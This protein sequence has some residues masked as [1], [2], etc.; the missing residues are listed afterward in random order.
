[1][2]VSYVLV[3]SVAIALYCTRRM[4]V[5]WLALE[6]EKNALRSSL[7]E[8][9]RQLASSQ[10]G[11]SFEAEA[12]VAR[13][14]VA[15]RSAADA[16]RFSAESSVEEAR[17]RSK[18]IVDAAEQQAHTI[19]RRAHST[20]G[21][22]RRFAEPAPTD[23]EAADEAAEGDKALWN[24]GMDATGVRSLPAVNENPNISRLAAPT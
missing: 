4:T 2:F 22:V 19:F 9:Q 6:A 11:A 8:A 16:L 18:A 23:D 1:M 5:R 7:A 14:L 3:A 10:A 12:Y 20:S 15:A 17:Q 24:D 21:D 13:L